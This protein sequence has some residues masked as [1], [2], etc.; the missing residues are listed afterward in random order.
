M[1]K[2]LYKSWIP[3]TNFTVEKNFD[4]EYYEGDTC[5]RYILIK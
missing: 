2:I 5:Y 3:S 1:K 4:I